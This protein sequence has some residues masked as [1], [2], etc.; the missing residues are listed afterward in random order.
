V[1]PAVDAAR[2]FFEVVQGE[3]L[4]PEWFIE[5]SVWSHVPHLLE[6]AGKGLNLPAP[7]MPLLAELTTKLGI[8]PGSDTPLILAAIVS[9]FGPSPFSPEATEAAARYLRQQRNGT[10]S[11][12]VKKRGPS[13][14]G[15]F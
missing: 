6:L 1:H 3:A 14:K 2:R 12:P 11:A 9:A 15:E 4:E 5:Q 10:F 7:C 8:P 13:I